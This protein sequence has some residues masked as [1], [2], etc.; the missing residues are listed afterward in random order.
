MIKKWGNE[1][2]FNEKGGLPTPFRALYSDLDSHRIF[3]PVS[4]KFTSFNADIRPTKI[5]NL[6]P[7]SSNQ[8]NSQAP[9]TPQAPLDSSDFDILIPEKWPSP[10][11]EQRPNFAHFRKYIDEFQDSRELFI[12][13]ALEAQNGEGNQYY[14]LRYERYC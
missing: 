9:K 7:V 12:S 10:R 4:P 13:C 6:M 14:K 8:L 2:A 3:F 11:V 5:S 1:K